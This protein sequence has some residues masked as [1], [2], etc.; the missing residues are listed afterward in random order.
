[1]EESLWVRAMVALATV[2][3]LLALLAAGLR[4]LGPRIGL[5]MANTLVKKNARLRVVEMQLLDGR[6]RA[7]LI[8]RDDV[9]HLVIIGGAQPVVV[10]AGIREEKK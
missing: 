2:I 7:L 9:E 4:V 6:H 3:G 10:E 5:T 8:R 1:M